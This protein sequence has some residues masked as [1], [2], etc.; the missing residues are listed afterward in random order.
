MDLSSGVVFKIK[1]DPYFTFK[2]EGEKISYEDTFY[3][4]NIK[5]KSA[6]I[7]KPDVCEKIIFDRK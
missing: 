1:I 2:K 4:E 3:F 7:A 6:F 5:L